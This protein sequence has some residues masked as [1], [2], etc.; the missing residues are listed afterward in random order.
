MSNS[1]R[2][3][4]SQEKA[5]DKSIEIAKDSADKVFKEAKRELP[6]V[7]S[8][9]HDYN[10]QNIKAIREMTNAFLESQ[11]E[12]AKSIQSTMTPYAGNPYLWMFL[13]WMHPQIVTESYF[14]AVSA[15]TDSSITAA[16][17]SSAFVQIM[18]ESERSSIEVAKENTKA[19]S[20]YFIESARNFEEA[21]NIV[22]S[23]T[24]RR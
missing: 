19:L 17:T 2:E 21:S 15:F 22:R 14:K 4:R 18:R 8:V 24:I 10:E 3:D 16:R 13:P 7:T 12:V 1:K 11:K 9:F 23:E 5:I 20:K 6:E